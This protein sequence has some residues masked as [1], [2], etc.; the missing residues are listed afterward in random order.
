MRNSI[1]EVFGC[2]ACSVFHSNMVEST[3]L[4]A[5][6][7]LMRQLEYVIESLLQCAPDL[8][9]KSRFTPLHCLQ[10]ARLTSKKEDQA[11]SRRKR[12]RDGQDGR[13][14]WI[15]ELEWTLC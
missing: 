9:L 5:G 11:A 15:S 14:Y 3:G 2:K 10:V 13:H 4:P 12:P 7:I 1:S 6:T 8:L